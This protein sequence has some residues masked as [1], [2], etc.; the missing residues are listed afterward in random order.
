MN[1]VHRNATVASIC[2]IAIVVY[3]MSGS[4]G[5]TEITTGPTTFMPLSS[6]DG[7]PEPIEKYSRPPPDNAPLPQAERKKIVITGGAG[8]IGSQL[9]HYL[10]SKGHDVTLIDNMR[11]GYE[12][13][14]VVDGKKFG[15][16]VLAD[17]LDTRVWK[18]LKNADAVYHFAALSALP[19]CQSHPRDAT[20]VNVGGVANILEGARQKG[21]K[22]FIFAST[23]ATYERNHE[24]VLLENLTVTPTLLYS[25][26]KYQ[27]EQ[28]VQ[29]TYHVYGLPYT[30]L[31]FFNVY[32]PHQDFRRT[33]PPFTSYVAREL[34]QGRAP[35]LHSDGEQ[36]RDYVH[37]RDLMRLAE[38]VMTHPKAEAETFNVASGDTYSV[39]EMFK[40]LQA[41][42]GTSVTP[43]YRSAEHFWDAYPELF[44]GA[45][46][47]KKKILIEE[48]TKRTV[49]S[50]EKAHR[51][52]GWKPEVTMENGLKELYS[53]VKKAVEAGQDKSAA[54]SA[55]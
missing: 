37:I 18:Y 17:V 52:V 30:I 6:N 35:K 44:H 49:G 50:Y 38:I 22:R 26:G 20:N 46:P 10:W 45:M 47:I 9:G 36:R 2:A 55:W 27:A 24:P 39:N 54:K 51:L 34:A 8:F 21:V 48:V 43:E 41:A 19:V 32:G 15:R 3:F 28:L 4:S 13:N 11:F 1:P 33:S 14:L 16:F 7:F 23:S 5:P 31:R 29:G 12:D 53:Y 42:A 25:L 40:I